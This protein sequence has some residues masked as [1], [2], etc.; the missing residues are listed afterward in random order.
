VPLL[1]K[2]EHW[3]SRSNAE[4]LSFQLLT[5]KTR[6][7]SKGG[8]FVW[9]SMSSRNFHFASPPTD[10]LKQPLALGASFALGF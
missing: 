10:M 8:D 3:G 2:W 9:R 7:A 4:Q 5:K 6:R 1:W